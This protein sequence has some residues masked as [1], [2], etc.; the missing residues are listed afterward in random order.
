MIFQH[1]KP[2]NM[3][4]I[5]EALKEV[6]TTTEVTLKTHVKKRKRIRPIPQLEQVILEI[7]KG[8]GYGGTFRPTNQHLEKALGISSRTAQKYTRTLCQLRWLIKGRCYM[9]SDLNPFL[10]LMIIFCPRKMREIVSK[11]VSQQVDLLDLFAMPLQLALNDKVL[12]V[13]LIW[14]QH[15][16]NW[17]RLYFQ[18][19]DYHVKLYPYWNGIIQFKVETD[20]KTHYAVSPYNIHWTGRNCHITLPIPFKFYGIEKAAYSKSETKIHFDNSIQTTIPL[21]SASY[22]TRSLLHKYGM[23]HWSD[24]VTRFMIKYWKN[25][26]AECFNFETHEQVLR[27]RLINKNILIKQI[28]NRDFI[29]KQFLGY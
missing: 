5:E 28:A 22:T 16:P 17:G 19:Q 7:M 23:K 4:W 27:D 10:E 20:Q 14:A 24:S 3:K 1:S 11:F 26:Y 29:V 13:E 9:W 18:K 8:I 21:G 12:N 25:E 15:E 2:V 6:A